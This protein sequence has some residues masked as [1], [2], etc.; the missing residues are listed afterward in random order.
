MTGSSGRSVL[1][2]D[3]EVDVS[4]TVC[5]ILEWN[6]YAV[7]CAGTGGDAIERLRREKFDIVVTDMFMPDVDGPQIIAATRSHQPATRVVAMSGGGAYMTSPD[8]L[9]VARKLGADAS[10]MKPFTPAQL[11]AAVDS[12]PAI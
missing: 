11:L 6:G 1:V 12:A 9:N 3:D 4:S 7:T 10:L 8:A 2:I 5:R